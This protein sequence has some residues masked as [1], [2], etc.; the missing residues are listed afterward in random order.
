DLVG[1]SNNRSYGT[2]VRVGGRGDKWFA[3]ARFTYLRYGDYRV[4]ADTVYVYD[5]AVPLNGQHLRNTAGRETDVHFTTGYLGG[6]FNSILYV[7]NTFHKAGFFANAHG[8][9][10]RRVDTDLHDRSARD[11]QLP[12]QQVNH[13][14]LISRNALHVGEHHI[15]AEL[16]FQRNFRQEHSPYV[17]HGY[18]PSVLPDTLRIPATLE[19]QFDK[20]V[21]SLNVKDYLEL[22]RHQVTFGLNGEYQDNSI[23]GWTFLVP[24]FEQSTAGVFGY[25]RY[26]LNDRILLHGA[27][28]FDY[29]GLRMRE[30]RDWFPSD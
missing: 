24:A 12:G 8:L 25:D 28:R 26:R 3:D 22:G 27:I 16:G 5:Y 17:N 23:G 18:M 7:S 13:F 15:E 20:Q 6:R 11:I 29:G 30:Y 1:R 14:K 10:P 2:S 4:P 19:R 21:Y 9:E